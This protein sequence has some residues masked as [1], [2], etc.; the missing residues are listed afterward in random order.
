MKESERKQ[1]NRGSEGEMCQ[2]YFIYFAWGNEIREQ[3]M[4]EGI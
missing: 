3:L 2:M 4:Y 1:P